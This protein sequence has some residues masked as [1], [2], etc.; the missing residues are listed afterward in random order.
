MIRVKLL[1]KHAVASPR[2]ETAILG[3]GTRVL[4]ADVIAVSDEAKRDYAKG[5]S[6]SLWVLSLLSKPS[7]GCIFWSND[8]LDFSNHLL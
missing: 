3:G 5:S 1:N 2:S 6:F 7:G 4:R 8:L